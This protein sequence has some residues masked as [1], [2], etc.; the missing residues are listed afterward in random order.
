MKF[1]QE[2]R[3]M[4]GRQLNSMAFQDVASGVTQIILDHQV[5]PTPPSLGEF[6]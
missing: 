4:N 6:A 3:V 2:F 1:V 5:A